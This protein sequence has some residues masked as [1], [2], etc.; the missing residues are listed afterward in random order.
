MHA[1]DVAGVHPLLLAIG[2]ERFVPYDAERHPRELLTQ[3]NAVLGF[4]QASLA[5]FLLMTAHQ[6]DPALSAHDVPAFFRHVLERM[7]PR[8]DL[9][10]QTRTTIDTLDYSGTGLN[11]GSKVV[12]AAAGRPLRTLGTTLPQVSL[13]G[14]PSV[15]LVLPGILAVGAGEPGE[16]APLQL[17]QALAAH[18]EFTGPETPWP[19]VLLVDDPEMVAAH[20]DNFLWVVFTRTNPS[21][22]LYGVGEFVEHKHWGC[23]GSVVFDARVKPHHAPPLVEDP[24]VTRRVDALFAK[25]GPLHGIIG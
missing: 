16:D 19:W 24:N 7:D 20:L 5:K 17:T 13:P 10:F 15:Q 1:V 4:N 12:I 14:F 18:A 8:R 21:H 23:T 2:S 6:D 22:D 3:A 25:G 11:E 9:H